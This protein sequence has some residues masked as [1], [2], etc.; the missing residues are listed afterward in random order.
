MSSHREP[1]PYLALTT[2]N[3]LVVDDVAAVDLADRFGTPLHIIVELQLRANV[4]RIRDAFLS[5][6]PHG[7][8]VYYS[9][10]ANPA[11]AVRRI[12]AQEDAGADCLGLHELRASLMVGTEPERLVLNGSNKTDE[13]LALAIRTGARI[14][15]DDLAEIDRVATAAIAANTTASVGVRVKPDL[16]PFPAQRSEMLDLSIQEYA[17]ISKWGLGRELLRVAVEKVLATP[18]L[19]L[20]GLHYHLG[21][22][23]AHPSLFELA[24][25]SLASLIDRK[26]VV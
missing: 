12:L 5:R 2:E 14:N 19:R 10:K 17:A 25:R 21:R 22:H 7:L 16:T 26:S 18:N 4:R 1:T 23:F 6:W 20:L 8:N 15:I 3:A 13:A 24:A 11:L 9:V